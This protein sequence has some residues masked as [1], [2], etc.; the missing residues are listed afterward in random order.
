MTRPLLLIAMT[1]GCTSTNAIEMT[2]M[3]SM[4]SETRGVVLYDDGQR[5][6]AAMQGTTCEFDTL[7]GW[8]ISD[9]DLPTDS[10]TMQDTY[11]GEVLGLSREGIHILE[12]ATTFEQ[13][14]FDVVGVL[15][16]RMLD[17]GGVASLIR[18][19]SGECAA[20]IDGNTLDLEP[21][22]CETYTSVTTDRTQTLFVANG[23]EVL[24][25]RK[26]EATKFADNWDLVV[27]DR[28][29]DLVYVA[30]RFST[31]VGGYQ[32]DGQLAWRSET[33]GEIHD[34]DDMGA[35]GMLMLMT[36]DETGE[37]GSLVVL[38][39]WSGEKLAEHGTPSPETDIT[40][41]EDGTT[42]AIVLPE[43]VYFYDVVDED[44]E[45]KVRQT[46][47]AE[48]PDFSD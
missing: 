9:H 45:P 42:M 1:A 4:Q 32:T 21:E 12:G 15:E 36:A 2:L 34:M 28:T 41:S 25:I 31:D 17:N 38:D 27:Y 47:G 40:L 24:A 6:H 39:G 37:R 35:R 10:E 33:Q 43:E 19:S 14:D 8:L 7:N 46:L 30:N 44:D 5:G 26:G 16:S 23:N 11:Q 3:S 13:T 20:R 48:R 29:T 18:H 22:I